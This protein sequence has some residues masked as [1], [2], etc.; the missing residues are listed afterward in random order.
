MRLKLW[1]VIGSFLYFGVASL[2]KDKNL[3]I[4]PAKD[5]SPKLKKDANAVCRNYEHEF[6]LLDYGRAIE[7]VHLVVTIFNEKGDRFSKLILPYDPS[8]KIKSITGR[9]YNEWGLPSDKLKNDAIQ[10]INYTT[11]GTIYDDLRIKLAEFKATNIYPY[12]VD[13]QFEIDYNG[14]IKYPD[15]IPLNTYQLAV[16]KST[17][18]VIFPDS[19]KIRYKELNLSSNC[20]KEKKDTG[21][22]ILEWNVDSLVA[23]KEEPMTPP[24][25][26][27]SPHVI[28]APVY[29]SYFG[30]NGNMSSW[31]SLGKWC[32]DLIK[33]T[34]EFSEQRKTEIRGLTG[35]VKDTIAAIQ[36]LY[37]YMQQKT[38]Y[39]SIQLGLGGYKP[40]PAET[41]DKLGY[42]DCKALSN[43]M[44]ALLKCVG[45]RSYY[46]LAGA[47]TNKGIT[48]PDFPTI[49]QNNHVILCVPLRKDTI[50][51]EC[52]SQT[53]ALGY[54]GSFVSNR[55]V[56]LIIETGGI[57]ARTPSLGSDDNKQIRV[58]HAK[59]SPDGSMQTEVKTKFTGYQYDNVSPLFSESKE[60][61]KKDLL[62]DFSIPGLVINSFGFN[63]KKEKI[64]EAIE[65]LNMS[66]NKYVT[67]SGARLF[68]PLNILNQMKD[69]PEKVENRKMPFVQHYPYHD[70]DS[71]VFFI[72]QGYKVESAP[73][74]K[75]IETEFGI[76]LSS[77]V[78]ADG[79]AVYIRDL[80]INKGT[81][82]KE[83]YL[84]LVDFY[85]AIVSADKARLILK[86][87]IVN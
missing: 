54:L 82:P 62:E 83:K 61:Q 44:K 58:V 26:S 29:F 38:R 85:S 5:I 37:K 45:I 4:Y 20:R 87:E 60:D 79:K 35:E 66:S 19:L 65:T 71:V 30:S 59:I 21:K 47:D 43:Y 56:L 36:I 55:K 7:K 27:Y 49:D 25:I 2:A 46:T 6:E 9:C 42:G 57:L 75:K 74:E 48:M 53:Q 64:P 17:F 12:T 72:P 16:E 10:D 24:L 63:T 80:K 67:K 76:Y 23:M 28:C 77:F 1:I 39:V 11:S 33:G 51:L 81:W 8:Q 15:W 34:D 70:Q 3:P 50:W 73:H 78:L 32:W 69:S 68:I 22:T 18:K 86:S 52:T 13:Y 31:K 40:F 84:A 41:V 14:L